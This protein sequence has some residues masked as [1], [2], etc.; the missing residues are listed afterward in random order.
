[1]KI[2]Y[3][4]Q[5]YDYDLDDLDVEQALRIEKHIGGTLLDWQNGLGTASTPA[6]Q[7]LGWIILHDAD[8]SMPISSVNFKPVK[9]ARAYGEAAEREAAEAEGEAD[10]TTLAGSSTPATPGSTPSAT[11]LPGLPRAA[12]ASSTAPGPTG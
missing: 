12:P 5:V 3:E 9:L 1:M 11:G 10:P 4:G 6:V 7:A 8:L 2:E